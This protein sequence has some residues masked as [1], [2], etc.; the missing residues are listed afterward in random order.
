MP[1]ESTYS[2]IAIEAIRNGETNISCDIITLLEQ[3]HSK[4]KS[5]NGYLHMSTL[6]ITPYLKTFAR[7]SEI[8]ER[9]EEKQDQR[10]AFFDKSHRPG[11]LFCP[12]DKV[13]SPSPP[14]QCCS[15]DS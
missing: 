9:I 12:N 8:R 1:D 10:K 4:R 15:E 6:R 5:C 7:T 11:P 2:I 3:L 14:Q 13:G